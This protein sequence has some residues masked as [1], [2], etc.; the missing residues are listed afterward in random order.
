MI[1]GQFG[2]IRFEVKD[3][4]VIHTKP[5]RVFVRAILKDDASKRAIKV[6]LRHE[7]KVELA[8]PMLGEM[9]ARC[10]ALAM[11]GDDVEMSFEHDERPNNIAAMRCGVECGCDENADSTQDIATDVYMAAS[12]LSGNTFQA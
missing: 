3:A 6:A 2:G 10:V 8:L 11:Q 4:A 7:T 9:R 12:R 5:H 1:D